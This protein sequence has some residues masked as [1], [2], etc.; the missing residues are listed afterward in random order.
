MVMVHRV[1]FCQTQ[2]YCTA[3]YTGM[4]REGS[5]RVEV[6]AGNSQVQFVAVEIN[7]LLQLEAVLLQAICRALLC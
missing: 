6:L 2:L 4:I 5:F 3:V 1:P 7:Y